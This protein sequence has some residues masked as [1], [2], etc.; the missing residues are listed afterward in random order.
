M[1]IVPTESIDFRMASAWFISYPLDAY[2][3]GPMR[4]DKPVKASVALEQ[5]EEQFG[6]LPTAIWPK[7]PVTEVDEYP[8]IIGECQE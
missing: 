1:K 3:L 5:A 2:A 4:F 6:E 8:I 7:G